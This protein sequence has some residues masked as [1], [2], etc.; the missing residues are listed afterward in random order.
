MAPLMGILST[1]SGLMRASSAARGRRGSSGR[2]D[3]ELARIRSYATCVVNLVAGVLD[4]SRGVGGT[5]AEVVGGGGSGDGATPV[6]RAVR[7]PLVV[8]NVMRQMMP[9]VNEEVQLRM[10]VS[11]HPAPSKQVQACMEDHG[12]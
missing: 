11:V 5:G 3:N 8:G 1:T 4:T 7:L 2:T 12:S 10:E 9:L 6:P